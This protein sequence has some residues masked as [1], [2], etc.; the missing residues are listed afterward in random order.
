MGPSFPED[1]MPLMRCDPCVADAHLGPGAG[2]GVRNSGREV[3]IG[4]FIESC[5]RR[6]GGQFVACNIDHCRSVELPT[7]GGWNY[8]Y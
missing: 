4:C 7:G 8:A 3:G 2:E 1:A 6:L 5:S